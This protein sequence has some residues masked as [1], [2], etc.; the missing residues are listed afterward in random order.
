MRFLLLVIPSFLAAGYGILAVSG[1]Y[2]IPWFGIVIGYFGLIEI[3]VMCSHCPH[4]AEKGNSLRCWANYGSPKIWRYRPGPMSIIEKVV[5]F[6]GFVC[7]WGYP[8]VFMVC[9]QRFLLLAIYGVTVAGFIVALRKLLCAQCM[10]FACPL[11]AVNVHVRGVFFELNPEIA[12]SWPEEE[13]NRQTNPT[14]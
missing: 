3:R 4:Y 14:L 11:N 10:N 12:R 8:V 2:L 6:G 5:F 1:W 7:I 9:A 13:R